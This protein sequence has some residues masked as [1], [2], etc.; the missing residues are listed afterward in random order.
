VVDLRPAAATNGGFLK[1]YDTHG[2]DQASLYASGDGT[3]EFTLNDTD[4]L[5]P[6][7]VSRVRL[8][9][10]LG[11]NA[12]IEI[13]GSTSLTE[14]G[15]ATSAMLAAGPGAGPRLDLYDP[16]RMSI[17][18]GVYHVAFGYASGIVD[19]SYTTSG[20]LPYKD[21]VEYTA[22][23]PQPD[24]FSFATYGGVD[25]VYQSNGLPDIV[26]AAFRIH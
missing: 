17:E 3:S 22:G 16:S 21:P 7:P 10:D 12:G 9:R 26:V 24:L 6:I 8:F 1:L 18:D 20:P 2:V 13:H 11:G 5:A 19:G 4:L 23:F 25:Y 14:P 15:P